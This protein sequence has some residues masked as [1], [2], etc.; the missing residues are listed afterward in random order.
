MN[1]TVRTAV[2]SVTLTGLVA[3]GLAA[4]SDE[5]VI[6]AVDKAVDETYEVTYEVTGRTSTRS[7][8]TWAGARP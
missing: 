4:C 6:D 1:H 8:S 2:L 7:S 5:Q 3:L